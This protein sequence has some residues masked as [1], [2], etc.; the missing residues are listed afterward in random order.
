MKSEFGLELLFV[1]HGQG[2]H[3]LYPPVSLDIP[4]PAL[5]KLGIGQAERLA[6][7]HPLN[8]EDIVIA[9]PTRRTIQTAVI[10]AES[11]GCRVLV[12]NAVG[13]RMFPLLDASK[14]L[15]CDTPLPKATIRNHF[16][17]EIIEEASAAVWEEGINCVSEERFALIASEFVRWCRTLGRKRFPIVSHDGTITAY[18][19][20][21]GEPNVTRSDFPG[22]ASLHLVKL[23]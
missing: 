8:V 16:S 23:E 13:P 1:R 12:H 17:I 5:T 19:R 3:T 10:W 2:E 9:S 15:R 21:L 11:F 20:L 7:T 6:E 22:E 4:D 14:A 18:R